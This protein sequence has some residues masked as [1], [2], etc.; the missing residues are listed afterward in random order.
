MNHSS[1][2][3]SLPGLHLFKFPPSPEPE[4]VPVPPSWAPLAPLFSISD[5][6]YQSALSITLPLTFAAI[7]ASAVIAI[8]HLNKQRAH[9]PWAISKTRPF[10]A[11]VVAHNLLLTVF[12]A[13]VFYG[14]NRA[15]GRSFVSPFGAGGLAGTVDSLCKLHGS[16]GLGNAVVFNTTSVAWTSVRNMR[17]TF[18]GFTGTPKG[19]DTGR[20]WNEGLA[21]YGWLFYISKYYEVVDTLIILAK[22]KES[23]LLQTYH[24]AGAILCMWA[25]IR[26]MSPPIWSFVA[27]NSF[28]HTLMVSGTLSLDL[29]SEA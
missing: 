26:W 27:V 13:W 22:G 10:F 23:S 11:I 9:K 28:I 5:S 1:V 16:P 21:F 29:P 12:S 7:Y 2:R 24:H 8:T 25:G 14:V 3:P 15:V 19:T 20:I 18:K 4:T 17:S 6:T